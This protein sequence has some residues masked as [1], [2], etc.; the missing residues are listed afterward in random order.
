MASIIMT[1][2][3]RSAYLKGLILLARKDFRLAPAE[4]EFVTRVGTTLGFH[5]GFAA[6]AVNEVLGNRHIVDEPP[7][8][9]SAD[10]A[11]CF[12]LDGLSL[13]SC[14]DEVHPREY[15]WLR[16]VAVANDLELEPL[17]EYWQALSAQH[18]SIPL[19]ATRLAF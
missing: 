14:D 15:L 4:V 7:V 18:E 8:F 3:D 10:V 9:S 13:S 17:V 5:E 1:L 19:Q 16:S 11:S 12:L 6:D 2:Q